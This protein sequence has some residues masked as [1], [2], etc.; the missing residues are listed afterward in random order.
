[1]NSVQP[2]DSERDERFSEILVACVEAVEKGEAPEEVI[3]HYP[4]FAPELQRFFATR[5]QLERLAI[6]PQPTPV[7]PAAPGGDEDTAAAVLGLGEL[8]DFRLLR[9]VGRGGMGVVYEAEQLSLKRRVALK[10]LPFAAAFDARQMQRFKHEAQAAAQLH[11]AH[12]VPVHAVGCERGVHFYAMQFVEGQTLA[13]LVRELRQNGGTPTGRAGGGAASAGALTPSGGALATYASTGGRHFFRRVAE[14]GRQVAE[15]LDYAH[16]QGVVHRDVKPANLLVDGQG[17]VWVADF[18]LA[19]FQNHAGPTLTGD[20]VGTLRYMSP[21]QA[22]A[23]RGLVDHRAD[24]YSLGVTLYE[25]VTLRPPFPGT[26][27]QEL[28]RLIAF[29]EPCPPRQLNHAVPVDLETVILKAMAKDPVERYAT[30]QELAEDL[31]RF[32]EDRPVLARRPSLAQRLVKWSRRHRPLLAAAG[33]ALVVTL[34]ALTAT[35]GW[36]FQREVGRRRQAE[37]RALLDVKALNRLLLELTD[38]QFP[39]NPRRKREEEQLFREAVATYEDFIR[40]M[41][42]SPAVREEKALAHWHLGDFHERLGNQPGAEAAY[43]QAVGLL[44][45]LARDAPDRPAHRQNQAKVLTSLGVVLEQRRRLAEA[46]AAHRHALETR[47]A[48]AAGSP[49]DSDRRKDLAESLTRL[50]QVLVKTGRTEEAEQLLRQALAHREAS[51]ADFPTED[52]Y[53]GDL[54]DTRYN[55]GV[56]LWTLKRTREAEA[57]YLQAQQALREVVGRSF[58]PIYT[59]QLAHTY[60]HLGL[61]RQ[62][63]SRPAEAAAAYREA[64]ALRRKLT[65]EF[66]WIPDFQQGLAASLEKLGEVQAALGETR[67]AEATLRQALEMADKLLAAFPEQP[68]SRQVLADGRLGLGVLLANTG[69]AREGEAALRQGVAAWQQVAGEVPDSPGHRQRLAHAH[70]ELGEFLADQGRPREAEACFREAAAHWVKLVA[71]CPRVGPFRLNL[72]VVHRQRGRLLQAA[73]RLD[74]AEA[75]GRRAVALLDGLAADFPAVPEYQRHRALG[76]TQL[77]ALLA[78]TPKHPE[79]EA[80]FGQAHTLTAKLATGFPKAAVYQEDLAVVEDQWGRWLMTRGR[81]A[82][83]EPKFR[84]AVALLEKLCAERPAGAVYP[85][86]L[87]YLLATCLHPQVCDPA[88][89]VALARRA[90]ERAPQDGYAWS[91]LGVARGRSGDWAGALPALEKAV[92]LPG[93]GDATDRFWLALAHAHLRR[94]DLARPSYEAAVRWMETNRPHDRDLCRLRAEA[95]GLLRSRALAGH[96]SNTPK[97]GGKSHE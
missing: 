50:G 74:E 47:Q 3:A 72:S 79:T 14:F 65:A 61:L 37:Q 78:D 51:V 17:K 38:E 33:L 35:A 34:M 13:A 32:L 71:S 30:A 19:Q 5:D 43:H 96:P 46:E 10:V 66:A 69:R 95:E 6:P 36:A 1:M 27:R 4:A 24:V 39:R 12:I 20:L 26:D 88:R 87:A 60:H 21:E 80:A 86:K 67:E 77:A 94:P 56:L 82:D 97:L 58:H 93:G 68:Y 15:A 73:G 7:R 11:H 76:Y 55:L 41:G 18:G 31:R 52:K 57:L 44:E 48:L 49:D 70:L 63:A 53:K 2:P 40:N 45:E 83:A 89:A 25:L 42:A 75:V 62:E 54:A 90:V 92:A 29:A 28:L 81:P 85:R 64:T 23:K 8:G 22:L 16:Q 91:V 84:A 9:E 59:V